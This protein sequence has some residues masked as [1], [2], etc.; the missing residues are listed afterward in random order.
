[1]LTASHWKNPLA[2]PR[3]PNLLVVS[4]CVISNKVIPSS[5]ICCKAVSEYVLYCSFC[6][7]SLS[8]SRTAYILLY[9]EFHYRV[10]KGSPLDHIMS[11]LKQSITFYIISLK[12][13][14]MLSS[15]L[16]LFIPSC[17]IAS[18]FPTKYLYAFL[19]V[20]YVPH[21]PSFSSSLIFLPR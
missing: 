18:D 10:H 9:P 14:L 7:N 11:R 16:R 2:T 3:F 1:M 12:S 21:A 4:I 8:W 6:R 15:H 19:I 20:P 17:L 5:L 13:T